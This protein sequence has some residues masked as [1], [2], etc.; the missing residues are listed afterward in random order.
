M[1]KKILLY[2]Y[3]LGFLKARFNP[4]RKIEKGGLAEE[5]SRKA[6]ENYPKETSFEKAAKLLNKAEQERTSL[7]IQTVIIQK[8]IKDASEDQREKMRKELEEKLP[9]LRAAQLSVMELEVNY[10]LE[11]AAQPK[12][13]EEDKMHANSAIAVTKKKMESL[14]NAPLAEIYNET[15]NLPSELRV[16]EEGESAEEMLANFS[17]DGLNRRSQ[18]TFDKSGVK[19][20]EQP[21]LDKAA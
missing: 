10:L 14:K 4:E 7:K 8:E 19:H 18:F 9:K 2:N 13:S 16:D 3:M 21:P 12:A 6:A 17:S 20:N 15:V 11:M 1:L 5:P